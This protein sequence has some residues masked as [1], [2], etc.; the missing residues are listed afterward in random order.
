MV[1]QGLLSRAST[2]TGLL[3]HARLLIGFYCLVPFSLFYV[4]EK[5]FKYK[6]GYMRGC[7]VTYPGI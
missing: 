6:P 4:S 3:I 1:T 2:R 5:Q 7:A